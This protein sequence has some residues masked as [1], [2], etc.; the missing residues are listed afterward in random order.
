M[1]SIDI[2]RMTDH[3]DNTTITSQPGQRDK[4]AAASD[5]NKRS[6][7]LSL[8]QE[9]QDI[10]FDF[11]YPA[12]DG[13]KYYDRRDWTDREQEA[14]R[15]DSSRVIR[16]FPSPKVEEFMLSRQYFAGASRAWAANQDFEFDTGMSG[17][18]R[19]PYIDN[20][21]YEAGIVRK[22]ATTVTVGM[23]LPSFGAR[24][25]Q[26][27]ACLRV[28]SIYL[29][30]RDFES[31]EPK[32]VW[33]QTLDEA[34]FA[35]VAGA[36][37][38]DK[39]RGLRTLRLVPDTCYYTKSPQEE[40]QW[41]DNVRDFE[42]Y[43]K[44]FITRP[45]EGHSRTKPSTETHRTAMREPPQTRPRPA[46]E[47]TGA[48]SKQSRSLAPAQ[49]TLSI[50]T[51]FTGGPPKLPKTMQRS[52][53]AKSALQKP[54]KPAARHV[55][56]GNKSQ[57]KPDVNG[58]GKLDSRGTKRFNGVREQKSRKKICIRQRR[59]SEVVAALLFDVDIELRKV[60]KDD[61]KAVSLIPQQP[62]G[63]ALGMLAVGSAL[64]EIIASGLGA[65][66]SEPPQSTMMAKQDPV[67]GGWCLCFS[68]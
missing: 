4:V 7:L 28:L 1:L 67:M 21:E 41:V 6:R 47:S 54:R 49:T 17:A 3:P 8:P 24:C 45:L 10:I 37:N 27:F 12:Q 56:R 11:A 36:L 64:P 20:R 48:S 25:R 13:T 31:T 44:P 18:F 42:A 65:V 15:R 5:T 55:D 26:H 32:F 34:D 9:L 35:V 22:H 40:Q 52:R 30:P 14:R 58:A 63:T 38:L 39:L 59:E 51:L 62:G 57:Q 68:N 2:H 16:P 66:R 29:S 61:A 23:Y 50:P 33:T 60:L 43:L 53:T 46:T 19:I